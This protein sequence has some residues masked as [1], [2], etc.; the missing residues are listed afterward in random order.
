MTRSKEHFFQIV[1]GMS[2]GLCSAFFILS[3]QYAAA[4][5][6][7]VR[8]G[9][10][11]AAPRPAARVG[12]AAA[13][14]RVTTSG[15]AARAASA[16]AVAPPVARAATAPAVRPVGAPSLVAAGGGT[17]A[18]RSSVYDSI[19]NNAT[20]SINVGSGAGGGNI[21]VDLT[22]FIR[23]EELDAE[24]EKLRR[25]MEGMHGDSDFELTDKMITE[26]LGKL[27]IKIEDLITYMVET[28]PVIAGKQD[29]LT[30]GAGIIIDG[31]NRISVQVSDGLLI[32]NGRIA[33]DPEV[34]AQQAQ[35]SM[36]AEEG[37]IIL[38]DNNRLAVQVGEGLVVH[39]GRVEIDQAAIIEVFRCDPNQLRM[40]DGQ[41]KET[42]VGIVF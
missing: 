11:S 35:Q 37:G 28:S 4:Q 14:P 26:I 39:G 13:A 5:T 23:W 42:C 38:D 3:A 40:T 7:S 22:G 27:D 1:R 2:V 17:A 25:E 30:M 15:S 8:T 36:V 19:R 18:R 34:I 41:G 20:G 6:T 32:E 29:A 21:D 33:I 12:N 10:A 16:P 31:N 9:G 24:I